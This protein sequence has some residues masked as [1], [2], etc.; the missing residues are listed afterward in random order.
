[1]CIT[2][3][4]MTVDSTGYLFLRPWSSV[5]PEEPPLHAAATPKPPGRVTREANHEVMMSVFVK[6]IT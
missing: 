3:N 1:M 2:Q 6:G 5:E 4:T